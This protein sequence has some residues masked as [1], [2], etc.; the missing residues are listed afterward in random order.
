MTLIGWEPDNELERELLKAAEAHGIP[1]SLRQALRRAAVLVPIPVLPPGD[2]S[3][4]TLREGQPL[5]LPVWE[6]GGDRYIP[7][8][9]SEAAL[10]WGIP[11][12]SGYLRVPV[13]VL[14]EALRGG[15]SLGLNLGG[16]LAFRL[17]A[18]LLREPDA[19]PGTQFAVGEPAEEPTSLLEEVAVFSEDRG[20]VVA[21]WRA[22]VKLEGEAPQPLIGVELAPGVDP[23]GVI[24]AALARVEAAGLDPV[25]M[26][27]VDREAP[28][29]FADY[30]LSSTR[31]FWTRERGS[32]GE[33]SG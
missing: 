18:A 12:G 16:P 24:P 5:E 26:V 31:P 13:T 29:A 4:V 21:A 28:D 22:L 8:Y 11:E 33:R 15:P 3:E 30:L 19:A 14:A 17:P 20:D 32:C 10:R 27:S 7:A 23:N 1:R 9:T 2:A 25:V 6:S